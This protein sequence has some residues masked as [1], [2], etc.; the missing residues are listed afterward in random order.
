MRKYNVSKD[1]EETHKNTH[2]HT[3][4]ARIIRMSHSAGDENEAVAVPAAADPSIDRNS[5]LT[6]YIWSSRADKRKYP[7]TNFFFQL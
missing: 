6:G 4:D 5:S 1:V 7:E 2:T 3:H